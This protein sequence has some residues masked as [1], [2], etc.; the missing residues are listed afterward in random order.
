MNIVLLECLWK[1][2]VCM[3]TSKY[4]SFYVHLP[5][6][7]LNFFKLKFL[8]KLKTFFIDILLMKSFVLLAFTLQLGHHAQRSYSQQKLK[9]L[10]SKK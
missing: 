6:F 9:V 2:G 8:H 1:C 10:N 7:Q 4:K 3:L 5:V